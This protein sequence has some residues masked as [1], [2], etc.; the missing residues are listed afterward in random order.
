MKNIMILFIVIFPVFTYAQMSDAYFTVISSTSQ[1][2]A[3][4]AAGSGSGT[5]YSFTVTFKCSINLVFD[6]VW[7]GGGNSLDLFNSISVEMDS[8]YSYTKNETLSLSASQ[9]YPGEYDRNIGLIKVKESPP[10]I[11][12]QGDALIKFYVNGQT[13]YYAVQGMKSLPDINYP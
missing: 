9:Y 6:S 1:N 11:N 10:P 2:W 8:E 5:N 3:G 4:G 12:Y 13:F 7:V